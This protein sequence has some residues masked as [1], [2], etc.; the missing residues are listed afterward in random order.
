MGHPLAFGF[1]ERLAGLAPG[2][3]D[4]SLD[5]VFF[6]NSGSESVDAALKIT[7]ANQGAIG[8]EIC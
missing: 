6:T 8:M 7:L 3:A 5:H 2:I 4:A 1:A